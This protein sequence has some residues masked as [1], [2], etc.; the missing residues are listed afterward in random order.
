MRGV[1]ALWFGATM[2]VFHVVWC[3]TWKDSVVNPR[4]ACAV[5]V[6]ALGLSVCVSMTI[7]AL[8][9]TRQL[10][11]AIQ[12]GSVLKVLEKCIHERENDTVTTC[13]RPH[14]AI[15]SGVGMH[16]CCLKTRQ[17][18]HTPRVQPATH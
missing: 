6:T 10:I 3:S 17:H 9:T 2:I 5:W 4:R 18:M 16:I 1:H 12:T 11:Q 15:I 8:Q 7:L 13:W 14:Y